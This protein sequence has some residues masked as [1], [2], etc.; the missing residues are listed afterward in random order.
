MIQINMTFKKM[1]MV[2][3]VFS[4][5]ISFSYTDFYD[6]NFCNNSNNSEVSFDWDRC[7]VTPKK[8]YDSDGENA[9][10]GHLVYF[11]RLMQIIDR[12]YQEEGND[13]WIDGFRKEFSKRY[14][15]KHSKEGCRISC[16]NVRS[17]ILKDFKGI[18]NINNKVSTL[19]RH[20]AIKRRNANI[21]AE[22]LLEKISE[23]PNLDRYLED[24]RFKG[25]YESLISKLSSDDVKRLK[26]PTDE[27]EKFTK[28][29]EKKVVVLQK[30]IAS[31]L[32]NE[33]KEIEGLSEEENS[34]IK[35]A[36]D[37]FERVVNSIREDD[38]NN[39]P[40][41][42][43]EF[44]NTVDSVI[45][46]KK[47][48]TLK[49]LR[50][51]INSL[52]SRINA[53]IG[54]MTEEEEN[55]AREILNKARETLRNRATIIGYTD[56]LYQLNN[57]VA[58]DEL[59]DETVTS[60]RNEYRNTIRNTINRIKKDY[61]EIK[62]NYDT[63]MNNLEREEFPIRAYISFKER[64]DNRIREVENNRN[65]KRSDLDSS[66]EKSVDLRKVLS[67]KYL[68]KLGS[69]I[70][71]AVSIKNNP[72]STTG[73]LE[74][75][76]ENLDKVISEL[77]GIN[78]KKK[79]LNLKLDELI[80]EFKQKPFVVP[81]KIIQ[82][83]EMLK[84]DL[85][86]SDPDAEELTKADKII[87][88]IKKINEAVKDKLNDDKRSVAISLVEEIKDLDQE[89]YKK[90]NSIIED[91]ISLAMI[92]VT[93]AVDKLNQAS[94]ASDEA[95]KNR[96]IEEAKEFVENAKAN[97]PSDAVKN[98]IDATEK[99]IKALEGEGR[100]LPAVKA[101]ELIKEKD[102]YNYHKLDE[103]LQK[104]EENLTQDQ[105]NE[106]EKDKMI[107]KLRE[108]LEEI[109]NKAKGNTTDDTKYNKIKEELEE[110]KKNNKNIEEMREILEKVEHTEDIIDRLNDAQNKKNS[111]EKKEAIE[112]LD[113]DISKLDELDVFDKDKIKEIYESLK[114]FK[115]LNSERYNNLI[116]VFDNV[117]VDIAN[118]L[119]EDY[120]LQIEVG[121]N[122]EAKNLINNIKLGANFKII[123]DLKLG[124]FLEYT[125]NMVNSYGVGLGLSYNITDHNVKSFVRYRLLHS[126]ELQVH[127]IDLYSKYTFTYNIKGFSIKPSI[128]IL[129]VYTFNSYIEEDVTLT[130]AF[131]AKVDMSTKVDYKGMYIE[132]IFAL[133]ANT[134]QT[135]KQEGMPSNERIIEKEALDIIDFNVRLGFEY[136]VNSIG[137]RGEIKA[138]LDKNVNLGLGIFILK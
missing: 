36:I 91:N 87:E 77:M 43:T 41:A 79:V 103:V 137:L 108:L 12:L 124:G 132:P 82:D 67:G 31:E 1:L 51:A 122:F 22:K 89:K 40:N 112:D 50:E 70:D 131:R 97:N 80:D 44:R 65:L 64:L 107:D 101:I 133:K 83:I 34:K 136:M 27:I 53:N 25:M 62:E 72:K 102:E 37:K 125:A 84:Q 45:Q 4:T 117:N 105:R 90:L 30:Q 113:E 3:A 26:L 98:T 49:K 10:T 38:F 54:N 76:K 23:M 135:L 110:L 56:L 42:E 2:V 100:L 20:I 74:Y 86:N 48:K 33:V 73:D 8:E 47:E 88:A 32:L 128:G 95:T 104:V 7:P 134:R 78:E 52:E 96:L 18:Y 55:T 118:R 29:L 15:E 111:T 69:A 75:A 59:I 58:E 127:N 116:K 11:S 92:E 81:D 94:K 66:I 13:P 99:S 68:K 121:K 16:T 120:Y 109:D 61:P 46:G 14:Y 9:H 123:K 129:G 114:K 39:I 106:F 24:P 19:F 60:R 126:G 115:D 130:G 17:R 57:V 21:R 119:D 138:G 5:I 28:Q 35:T 6:E 71:K 63:Y 93:K 85:A